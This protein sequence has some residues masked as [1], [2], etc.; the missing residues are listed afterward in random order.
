MDITGFVA[1]NESGAPLEWI[2]MKDG[3]PTRQFPRLQENDGRIR[4]SLDD[5]VSCLEQWTLTDDGTVVLEAEGHTLGI[6]NED[7]GSA[8]TVDGKEIPMLPSDF[9]FGNEGHFISAAFLAEALGGESLWD[10]E[11]ST[12][13]L[14]IPEAAKP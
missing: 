12:L 4:I 14:R 1:Y 7:A 9:D 11:E 8:A 6:Y 3:V 2:A 10:A 5:L 13:I